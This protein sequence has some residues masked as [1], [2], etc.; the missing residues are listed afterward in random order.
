MQNGWG[1]MGL[2]V[3]QLPIVFQEL[4]VFNSRV[5]KKDSYTSVLDSALICNL[6]NL[7]TVFPCRIYVHILNKIAFKTSD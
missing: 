5:F 3:P 4:N 2:V 1:F 7:Q 6:S